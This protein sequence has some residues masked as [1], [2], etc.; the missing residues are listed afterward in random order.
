LT[1]VRH[2]PG[3]TDE[4][5]LTPLSDGALL[6]KAEHP[7][8]FGALG[9]HEID[10]DGARRVVIRVIHPYATD[11]DVLFD[12]QNVPVASAFEQDPGSKTPTLAPPRPEE[13]RCAHMAKT[14]E[15]FLRFC[16]GLQ[17]QPAPG[18]PG[19]LTAK[20]LR[21]RPQRLLPRPAWAGDFRSKRRDGRKRSRH[22]GRNDDVRGLS[23]SHD[24]Q[25]LFW[26]CGA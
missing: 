3:E 9:P 19:F 23:I 1:Q 2:I 11:V 18:R 13:R 17:V 15:R 7:D 20:A 24:R 5:N 12:V 8:P 16:R 21:N 6:V 25:P 4:A 14:D 10:R 22:S 26:F